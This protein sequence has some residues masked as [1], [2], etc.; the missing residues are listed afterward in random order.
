MI[1]LTTHVTRSFTRLCRELSHKEDVF[2]IEEDPAAIRANEADNHIKGGGL[3]GAV[4][5]EQ[6]DNLAL[7]YF[8]RY[9]LYDLSPAVDLIQ[10]FS[11]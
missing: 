4:G 8:Q 9:L 7:L 5:A 2:F 10:I 1:G 3:P 6:T 11:V